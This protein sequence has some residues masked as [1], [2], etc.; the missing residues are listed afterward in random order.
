MAETYGTTT[1]PSD[2]VTVR[3]GGTVS[4]GAAFET[5]LGL[6]GGMDTANGNATSGDVITV[7]STSDAEQQFGEDSELAKNV[8]AAYTNGAG[9]IYAVGVTETQTTETFSSSSSGTLG[10]TPVFDPNVQPEHEITATDTVE[11][12]SVT[13]NIVYG[14]PSSPTDANTIN[15]NPVTGEW[16]ADE[17]SDYDIDYAYG[18]Y[19]SAITDVV[20]KVPRIVTVLT[21]STTVASSLL[22][23]LNTYDSDFD[24]M[25]GVVGATPETI[26]SSYSDSIDD[27]RLS[28]VAPSRAWLDEAETDQARIMGAVGGRASGKP[29]G[30]SMTYEDLQG[31]ASLNTQYTNSELGTLID[32]Q[33]MPLRQSGGIDIVKDM[34]TSTDVR[35]ERLYASEIIDE[36]TEISHE[37]SQ[38][39]IGNANTEDN[40]LLLRESHTTSYNELLEDNLLE[41]FLVNVS[42]GADDFEVEIDI[43]LD[44]IGIIDTVDVT[45]TVGDVVQNGGAA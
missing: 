18:D 3:S 39:F 27:R 32:N 31:F 14:T 10:D 33:V 8:A 42:K 20:K 43:G 40:R 35:F 9:T 34:T 36:A 29:L 25:H 6:V 11:S 4:I 16:E 30:D 28:I 45:I 41:D 38:Q 17:S 5:T 1:I 13:V 26:A 23:E 21:E 19:G 12:A 37:I 15:L 44:V 7:E 24:F 2:S 22:S